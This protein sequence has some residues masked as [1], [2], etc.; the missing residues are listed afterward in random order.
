MRYDTLQVLMFVCPTV[1]FMNVVIL[2]IKRN[3]AVILMA[4]LSLEIFIFYAK[5]FI[6]QD[7]SLKKNSTL[8]FKHTYLL[9]I[10]RYK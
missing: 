8:K 7:K 9:R 10:T 1:S 2:V 6:T 3:Y 5:A 4:C